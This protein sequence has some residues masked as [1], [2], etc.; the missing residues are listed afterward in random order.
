M[1]RKKN[2]RALK[3]D[4]NKL[5]DLYSQL[6]LPPT[7]KILYL[8]IIIKFQF[9]I[10]SDVNTYEIYILRFKKIFL[11]NSIAIEINFF[12]FFIRVR[13]GNKLNEKI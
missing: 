11:D 9:V 4:L 2:F 8:L 1:Q 7:I 5:I 6:Q 10:E 12:N 13:K 3:I